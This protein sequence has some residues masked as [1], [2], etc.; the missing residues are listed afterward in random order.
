[1]IVID[2][3]TLKTCSTKKSFTN[4][5]FQKFVPKKVKLGATLILVSGTAAGGIQFVLRVLGAAVSF[6]SPISTSEGWRHHE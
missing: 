5:Y 3:K 6:A 1:V 2:L 4:V